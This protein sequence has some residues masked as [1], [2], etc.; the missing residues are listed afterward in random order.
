[1]EAVGGGKKKSS[2]EARPGG[3]LGVGP[4][5]KGH[6]TKGERKNRGGLKK[7]GNANEVYNPRKMDIKAHLGEKIQKN[8][9]PTHW[10]KKN[11]CF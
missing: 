11:V 2:I 7:N 10:G 8:W 4:G 1:V 9:C 5:R 3:D 6:V